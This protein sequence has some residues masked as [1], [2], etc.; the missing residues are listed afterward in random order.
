M[1]E[2]CNKFAHVQ[3]YI[4]LY[5]CWL[6]YIDR[7]SWLL[8]RRPPPV[9]RSLDL[10]I[11]RMLPH[12]IHKSAKLVAHCRNWLAIWLYTIHHVPMWLPVIIIICRRPMPELNIPSV[13]WT[14][15][16]YLPNVYTCHMVVAIGTYRTI[17]HINIWRL[18]NRFAPVPVC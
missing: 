7:Y 18:D 13:L 2:N 3:I 8:Q 16:I 9:L 14:N 11:I 15:F 6:I 4:Y 1:V 10:T 5:I 12:Q 17:P